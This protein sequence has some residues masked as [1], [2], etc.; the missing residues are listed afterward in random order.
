ML[1]PATRRWIDAALAGAALVLGLVTVLVPDWFERVLGAS[2]DGGD[3]S[4]ERW[5]ALAWIALAVAL[6]LLARRDHRRAVR[7]PY[8]ADPDSAGDSRTR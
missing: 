2:P 6:A 1:G 7:T 5:F 4:A 3:G 8:L